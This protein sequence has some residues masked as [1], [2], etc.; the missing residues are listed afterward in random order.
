[1]KYDVQA[2]ADDLMLTTDELKEI[3]KCYFDETVE[4]IANAYTA[5]LDC[6]Y[7]TVAKE[8]H[9]LKGSSMNFRMHEMGVMAIELGNLAE[10]EEGI[11]ISLYLSKIE[12]ELEILKKEIYAFYNDVTDEDQER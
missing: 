3:F 1:M 2:A 6:D 9:A 8:M 10:K 5:N 12:N 11:E 7:I 4:I